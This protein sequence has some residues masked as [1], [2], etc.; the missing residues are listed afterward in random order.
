[1]K[2]LWPNTRPCVIVASIG[3]SGSTLVT[4]QLRKSAKTIWRNKTAQFYPTLATAELSRGTICKTHDYPDALKAR[5]EPVKPLFIFGSTLDS[6]LSVHS[7]K[8]RF[9]PNWVD[10]HLRHLKSTGHQDDLFKWDICGM[11]PQ[12]KSWATFDGVP[13]LCVRYDALWDHIKDIR[14]FTGYRFKLPA[15]APRPPKQI[16]DALMADARRVYE[17]IDDIVMKLP[18][19]FMAGPDMAP[20]VAGL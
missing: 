5:E 15:F 8:T 13:T 2:S 1:M 12:I 17:P 14:R 9:S 4:G 11:G 10:D 18:T 16:D 19:L 3:R 6:A 7:C 20:Q